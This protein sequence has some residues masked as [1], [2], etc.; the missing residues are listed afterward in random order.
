LSKLASPFQVYNASAGSGKTF[1]IVKQYL[2]ILFKSNRNDYYKNILAITFTNKAVGE[3]KTR[4]VNSLRDFSEEETPQKSIPLFEAVKT[5]TQLSSEEIKVKSREIIKNILHNYAAFDVSTID[6]FTHRVLRTF[7]KDL[8]LPLNFEVELNTDEVLTEAVDKLISK[9]GT[10]KKLTKTL[11]DFAIAKADDDKSWDIAKDLYEISRLLVNENNLQVLG[12]LEGYSIE[13]FQEFDKELSEAIVSS[14]EKIKQ[15]GTAFFD[16][17]QQNALEAKDYSRKS[18]PNHFQRLQ[19]LSFTVKPSSKKTNWEKEIATGSHYNKTQTEGKKAT[20]DA[21]Q[22]Q[23]SNLYEEADQLIFKIE[24]YQSIQKN[25]TSLSLLNLIYKEVETLKAEKNL[26]LIS[27]FNRKIS[28]T[29]KDQ[30][31]PFI[32]ERLGERYQD[33]FIDE[34]QDTSSLQWNNLIPLIENN[35]ATED[36]SGKSKGKLFLVGDAKQSIYRWR[37]GKAEQFIDL[38]EGENP[39]SVKKDTITLPKN[40]RS[41]PEIVNFNNN[42]FKYC[43]Q[44]LSWEKYQKLFNSSHQEPN[45]QEGGYVQ[46]DFVEAINNEEREEVYPQK[47]LETIENLTGKGYP[48]RDICILVRK[49]AHGYAVANFLNE[50]GIPIIS[51]ESLL[52]KNSAEVNF[53]NSILRSSLQP[54]DKNTKFEILDYLFEDLVETS[55]IFNEIYKRLDKNEAHFFKSLEEFNFFFDVETLQRLPLYD[56]LEYTIRAFQLDKKADA[57][58]QFYLDFV[59]EYTQKNTGIIAGFLDHWELKKDKL[60][61]IAP[62]GEDAVQIMTIHTAKGLE[63]PI[64]IYPYAYESLEDTRNDNIWV[65][66][67]ETPNKIPVA[68]LSANKKMEDFGEA[69]AALF[70]KLLIENEFDALNVLYVALTRPENQLYIISEVNPNKPNDVKNDF[71]GLLKGYL[72]SIGKWEEEKLTYNFGG[73]EKEVTA[74]NNSEVNQMKF[75]SSAPANH[76]IS[77]ITKSGLLWDTEQEEAREKGNLIHNLLMN[78]FTS[79]DI[80]TVLNKAISNGELMASE[81]NEYRSKLEEIVNHSELADYFSPAYK[82]YNEKELITPNGFKRIDRLCLQDKNAVI[83]DYKTGGEINTHKNQ[84]EEYTQYVSEM[85]FTI[86]QKILVYLYPAVTVNI[87]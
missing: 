72:M 53:L 36:V 62:E 34:F 37:G 27:E 14:E 33:F 28:N 23:V 21:I 43:A 48:K 10:D 67:L 7:A 83:I 8:G 40:F 73:F 35:L 17:M 74:G 29:I 38:S 24:F 82:I 51:T 18:I 79:A 54:E 71:S 20:M 59:Y 85:G 49:K 55:Q 86:Q 75:I 31:A 13:D 3:M 52:V 50:N 80:E 87:I 56:A 6:G 15:A 69:P 76:N 77:L 32:Y 26:L 9:A 66:L 11:L 5:E 68:Y 30:P 42:F 44:Q 64:V 39:F 12:E 46:V 63:F 81:E 4:I 84:L 65:P 70:Q 22:P 58:L 16:L 60:S 41:K 1:T 78:I 25:L 2:S 47:V 19:D 45:H 57:Y 61:V